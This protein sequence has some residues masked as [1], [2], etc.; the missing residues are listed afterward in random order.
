MSAPQL[1][2]IVFK[3]IVGDRSQLSEVFM[4]QVDVEVGGRFIDHIEELLQDEHFA[5]ATSFT[6]VAALISFSY[7]TVKQCFPLIADSLWK[8][9]CEDVTTVK[10]EDTHGKK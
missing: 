8:M 5:T 10:S 3:D 7:A 1:A 4:G 6:L 2:A 9:L